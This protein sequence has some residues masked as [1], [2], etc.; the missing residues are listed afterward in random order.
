MD[1]FLKQL[2]AKEN[3]SHDD[4]KQLHMFFSVADPSVLKNSQLTKLLKNNHNDTIKN[5][6]TNN[7]VGWYL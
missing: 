6:L 7:W 4:S 1:N 3:L 5:Y 2:I